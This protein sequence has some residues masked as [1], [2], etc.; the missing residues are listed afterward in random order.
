MQVMA[1]DGTTISLEGEFAI[2]GADRTLETIAGTQILGCL[3]FL[4][5]TER[6][7]MGAGTGWTATVRFDRTF[8]FTP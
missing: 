5:P 7:V 2:T 3:F 6:V 4:I 1:F 8:S